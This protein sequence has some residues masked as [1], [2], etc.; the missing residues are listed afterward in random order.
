M[1]LAC[2]VAK[3]YLETGLREKSYKFCEQAIPQFPRGC[4]AELGL[5]MADVWSQEGRHS[6]ALNLLERSLRYA[7]TADDRIGTL[8]HMAALCEGELADHDQTVSLLNRILASESVDPRESAR[9]RCWLADVLLAQGK[10]QEAIMVLQEIDATK[11]GNQPVDYLLGIAHARAGR[12]EKAQ[13][14]LQKAAQR[15]SR[16]ADKA[17][18][19]LGEILLQEQRYAEAREKF[20]KIMREF[21]SSVHSP[22]ARE[23]LK[24]LPQATEVGPD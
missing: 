23:F 1:R 11:Y 6:E 7:T 22:K 20:L 24:K 5:R 12:N 21:P 10:L 17:L 19:V 8:K 3:A 14:H 2:D 13:F 4:V 9:L 15:T 18:Y 16:N